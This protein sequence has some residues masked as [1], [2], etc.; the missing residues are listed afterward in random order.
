MH[1]FSLRVFFF[2]S[3]SIA[4][5]G[6]SK[7]HTRQPQ[8]FVMRLKCELN[9]FYERDFWFTTLLKFLDTNT[10]ME[11]FGALEYAI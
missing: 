7:I 5:H 4:K 10:S 1:K 2:F 8:L 3:S 6:S 11:Y 9:E